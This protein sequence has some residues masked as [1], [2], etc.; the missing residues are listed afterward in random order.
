[1]SQP[2][3]VNINSIVLA[4][5][6]KFDLHIRRSHLYPGLPLSL[7]ERGRSTNRWTTLLAGLLELGGKPR[8]VVDL[9]SGDREGR[10]VL[11]GVEELSG[12]LGS[13]AGV[14]LDYVPARDHVAVSE[15][16]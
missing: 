7:G 5:F 11:Q 16:L 12:G 2:T 4:C 8:T 13:G 14:G 10:A 6:L 1:M 15:L 9:Q 3:A